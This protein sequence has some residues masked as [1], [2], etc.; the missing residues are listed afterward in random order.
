MH[1]FR[2]DGNIQ[3]PDHLH[4]CCSAAFLLLW[5]ITVS[6]CSG[7]FPFNFISLRNMTELAMFAGN[8]ACCFDWLFVLTE[9]NVNY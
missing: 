2:D 5:I 1:C 9:T 7:L 3:L 6:A 8:C 4:C